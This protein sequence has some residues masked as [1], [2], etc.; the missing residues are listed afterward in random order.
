MQFSSRPLGRG[1]T[2]RDLWPVAV[3]VEEEEAGSREC[4]SP[5][6]SLK[7]GHASPKVERLERTFILDLDG[8]LVNGDET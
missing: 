8:L 5:L 6:E 2:G 3:R 1:G 7:T 4:A